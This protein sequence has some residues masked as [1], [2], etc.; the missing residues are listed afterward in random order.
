VCLGAS[1]TT[2]GWPQLTVALLPA[3]ARIAVLNRGIPG[4]RLRFDAPSGHAS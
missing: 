4:N 3:E 1:I 2:M